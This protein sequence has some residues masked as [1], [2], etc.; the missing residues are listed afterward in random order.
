MID[1]LKKYIPQMKIVLMCALLIGSS[2]IQGSSIQRGRGGFQG[3]NRGNKFLHINKFDKDSRDIYGLIFNTEDTLIKVGQSDLYQAVQ[4]GDVERAKNLIDQ[5]TKSSNRKSYQEVLDASL[6][7]AASRIYFEI[8][9]NLIKAGANP[10]VAGSTNVTALMEVLRYCLYDNA[11]ELLKNGADLYRANNLK[12]TALDYA[13]P[14]QGKCRIGD[15]IIEFD[16]VLKSLEA[17]DQSADLPEVSAANQDLLGTLML[18]LLKTNKLDLLKQL[19]QKYKSQN[20]DHLEKLAK[21]LLNE[22][23]YSSQDDSLAQEFINNWMDNNLNTE[24]L[25]LILAAKIFGKQDALEMKLY[26]QARE[27]EDKQWRNTI[28]KIAKHYLASNKEAVAE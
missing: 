22:L 4:Q 27:Q 28:M 11:L 5:I 16:R 26:K 21:I 20:S 13:K 14:I 1:G 18:Y 19:F 15:F 2:F 25:E 9:P 8:I 17:Q 10:N 12:Q 3:S 23:N 7:N 6:L 24:V